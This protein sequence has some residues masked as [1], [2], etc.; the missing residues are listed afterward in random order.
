VHGDKGLDQKPLIY[1]PRG[2]DLHS[3][4]PTRA[5]PL[6]QDHTLGNDNGQSV[7]IASG[8]LAAAMIAEGVEEG[9]PIQTMVLAAAH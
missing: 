2:D 3:N 7:E 1:I 5:H 6:G 9:D 4:S 8:I